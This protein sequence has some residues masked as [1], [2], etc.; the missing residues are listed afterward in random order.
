MNANVKWWERHQP[1]R[2]SPAEGRG[3]SLER[4]AWPKLDYTP[5][6]KERY[7]SPEFMR[8]EWERMWKKVWLM[9]IRESQIPKAGDYATY[10]LGKENFILTRD[11]AGK[12]RAY[13]NVCLHRGN[14]LRPCSSTQRACGHAESFQCGYHHWEWNLDGTIKRIPEREESFPHLEPEARLA[15]REVR[16]DTWG[17]WVWINMDR[18][19]MPLLEYLDPIPRHFAA[20]QPERYYL[21]ANLTI[22]WDCNW[23]TSVDAFNEAYHVQ[24]I[25]PQLYDYIDDLNMQFDLYERHARMLVPQ[26]IQSPRALG[27]EKLHHYTA[28]QLKQLGVDLS[29]Y[30]KKPREARR[31]LHRAKRAVQDKIHFPYATLNDEQLTDD[32]HYTIFPNSQ[33]NTY[34][35]GAMVFVSRPHETDPNKMY[36]DLQ[37]YTHAAPGEPGKDAEH[38]YIT[39]EQLDMGDPFL[40]EVLLQDAFN[41][42]HVQA[43]MRSDAYDV[44]RI[45][46]QE[47]RIAFFHQVLMRYVNAGAA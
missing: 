29:E 8:L 6:P 45:G 18:N 47:C 7:T 5:I 15:L 16:A 20:Y 23:K 46:E 1:W 38:R 43:G 4:A 13:Y 2:S 34:A 39:N 26:S 24:G 30:E 11:R 31:A 27:R 14:R 25:H 28:M 36:W 22:P 9:T 37:F 44:L 19:A 33:F 41:L 17:G 32:Y 3:T 21:A 12:V 40:N 10:D 42:P 35:E